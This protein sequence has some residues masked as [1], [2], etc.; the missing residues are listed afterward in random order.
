MSSYNADVIKLPRAAVQLR[1]ENRE[2]TSE[3]DSVRFR[4]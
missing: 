4:G 3:L 1:S 2:A